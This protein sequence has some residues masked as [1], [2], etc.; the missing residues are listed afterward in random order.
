[1][2][3]GCR[4]VQCVW[5]VSGTFNFLL[6]NKYPYYFITL[7]S[8]LFCSLISTSCAILYIVFIHALVIFWVYLK[9]PKG[10]NNIVFD[11]SSRHLPF[12]LV[13]KA[14]SFHVLI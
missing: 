12:V 7:I 6:H 5:S 10:I 2:A 8:V 11:V 9:S 14:Y 1:M 4:H 13:G 3:S